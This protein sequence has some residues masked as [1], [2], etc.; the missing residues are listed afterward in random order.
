MTKGIIY[1]LGTEEELGKSSVGAAAMLGPTPSSQPQSFQEWEVVGVVA[2]GAA[3]QSPSVHPRGLSN[4]ASV[5]TTK[6]PRSQRHRLH[7]VSEAL[8]LRN[9][10]GASLFSCFRGVS[11]QRA[12]RPC[13]P[14]SSQVL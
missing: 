14:A 2:R 3:W 6:S 11:L 1:E 9:G 4:E 5:A 12:D 13:L 7:P 10:C 8:R